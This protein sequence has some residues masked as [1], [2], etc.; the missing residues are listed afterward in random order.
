[1]KYL[2]ALVLL[3]VVGCS[4]YA[5]PKDWVVKTALPGSLKEISGITSVGADIYAIS[6][7]P[8]PLLYK[9]DEKG[10]LVATINISNFIANDVEAI[11]ADDNHLYIGDVGDNSGTRKERTILQIDKSKLGSS[12]TGE[13]IV[14]TFPDEK[15]VDKK[16]DNNYDCEAIAAFKG[17]LYVFT[18]DREDKETRL[19]E[20]PATPGK[21]EA[22]FISTFNAKGLITD[23]AFNANGTELALTGYHKGH[24]N[25]FV[26]L[27]SNFKGNDFFSGN[28]QKIHLGSSKAGWQIEGITYGRNN[29][30]YLT[31]EGNKKVAANFYGIDRKNLPALDTKGD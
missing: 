5:P 13:A 8:R 16:K 21:H 20:V 19:Y 2:I 4:A 28:H 10:K 15:A 7:K 24:V 12:V 17:A 31:S 26:I 29:M 1:M 14:F 3:M 27:F 9:L 6:D 23:A 30:I 11:T 18:K 22:K 25:P